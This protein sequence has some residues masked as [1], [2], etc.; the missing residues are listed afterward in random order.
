MSS[1]Q[2]KRSPLPPCLASGGQKKSCTPVSFIESADPGPPGPRERVSWAPQAALALVSTTVAHVNGRHGREVR[3]FLEHVHKRTATPP[4]VHGPVLPTQC[5]LEA[6][7]P[8]PILYCRAAPLA[9]QPGPRTECSSNV[10]QPRLG[11]LLIRTAVLASTQP[12]SLP[13]RAAVARGGGAFRSTRHPRV[14]LVQ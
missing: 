2:H 7:K 8:L 9:G 3:A 13:L 4:A 12:L 14:P 11:M 10:H 1:T 5:H 6:P